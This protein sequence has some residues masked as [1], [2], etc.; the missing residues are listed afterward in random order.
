[1]GLVTA[2]R[3]LGDDAAVAPDDHA[4]RDALIR[5]PDR[6]A[7]LADGRDI[8]QALDAGLDEVVDV[9]IDRGPG[10]TRS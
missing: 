7:H 9:R 6:S 1:M 3:D 10:A 8:G 4:G 5:E 2:Y